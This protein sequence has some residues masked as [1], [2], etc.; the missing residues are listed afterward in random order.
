MKE[1]AGI[2][3][4]EDKKESFEKNFLENYRTI[5]ETNTLRTKL[6]TAEQA[7]KDLQAKYDTDLSQRDTD[8]AALKEQLKDA[9][10]SK[11]K[12]AELQSKFDTLSANYTS[13]KEEYQ[14]NLAKEHKNNIIKGLVDKINFTSIGAKNAFLNDV[15]EKDL[16]LDGD[17]LLGFDDYKEAYKEKD[18]GAFST[19]GADKGVPN[20]SS[21]SKKGINSSP[22]NNSDE[23]E[24]APITIW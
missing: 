2:E 20:F 24:I 22:D 8:L 6:T 19:E 18:P 3:V 13:A 5:N 17:N 16:Q 4:P 9:G 21:K 12:L 10:Q 1:Q 14:S 15:I 23:D 11:D 7:N